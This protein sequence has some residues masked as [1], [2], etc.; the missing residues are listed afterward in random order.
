M[1]NIVWIGCAIASR[2]KNCAD[3]SGFYFSI[4][5]FLVGLFQTTSVLA[6][7]IP[8]TIVDRDSISQITN[9]YQLRDVYPTDWSY[10]A[11]RS[12]TERYNCLSGFPN[13]T[14]QGNR[15]LTRYEFTADLNSCLNQIEGAIA[16]NNVST[17]DI[18]TIERLAQDFAAELAVLS[19]RIDSLKAQSN[20]PEEKQFSTTTKLKGQAVFAVNAGGFTGNR[21]IDPN[22]NLITD[23]QPQSTFLYRVGLDFDTSF[24][25]TDN[26]KIRLD[27]GSQGFDDNT[28]GFLEPNFGSTLDFSDSPPRQDVGVGRLYYD[29]KPIKNLRVSLGSV[30]VPTDY[31]DTNSYAN[32]NL[33][34][35]YFDTA[36]INY[37]RILF[38]IDGASTGAFIEWNPQG[39]VFTIRAQYNSV[40]AAN[41]SKDSDSMVEGVS[42]FTLLLYPDGNGERGLFGDFYQGMVELE[43]APTDAFAVRLQYSGGEIF[44][45]RFD[46]VGANVEWLFLPKTALFARYGYGSYDNTAF[47]DINPNY[48]MA[49]FSLLD[50]FKEGARAGIAATQPFI[51]REIGNDTQT[52]FEIFYELPVNDAILVTPAIQVITNASNQESN[53]TIITGTIRTVFN[54]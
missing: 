40:D 30:T 27:S 45:S 7:T 49:G 8:N 16:N 44:D 50:L 11:L 29:F 25:G 18:A 14:F 42:A 21:I 51:A 13:G 17:E 28:A 5:G 43:Y 41:P 54:F 31:I 12:L 23:S 2:Q 32:T 47:G 19:E 34:F 39:K 38:P 1:V 37:N 6:Q 53:D 9:V 22:G 24:S 26:L 48:W 36:A 4:L 3:T 33:D 46:V 52:N 20:N 15:Y 10:K 35:R